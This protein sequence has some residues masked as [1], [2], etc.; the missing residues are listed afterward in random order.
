MTIQDVHL[1]SS[2][3]ISRINYNYIYIHTSYLYMIYSAKNIYISIL[4]CILYTVYMTFFFEGGGD[5]FCSCVDF[6][7]PT[8]VA[9]IF[10]GSSR[11]VYMVDRSVVLSDLDEMATQDALLSIV[12]NTFFSGRGVGN[13]E[14]QLVRRLVDFFVLYKLVLWKIHVEW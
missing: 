2:P 7:T 11:G 8:A 14:M 12:L 10:N 5:G 6:A 13:W 3:A 9:V 1:S 4:I